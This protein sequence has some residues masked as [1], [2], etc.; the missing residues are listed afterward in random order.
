MMQVFGSPPSRVFHFG[1]GERGHISRVHE[2]LILVVHRAGNRAPAVSSSDAPPGSA[3]KIPGTIH[4]GTRDPPRRCRWLSTLHARRNGAVSP[5]PPIAPGRLG[6]LRA[7]SLR[8]VWSLAGFG[9]L[10][11]PLPAPPPIAFL[12]GAA[13]TYLDPVETWEG[14]EGVRLRLSRD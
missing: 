11:A 1:K 4:G 5:S 9:V 10:S 8:R 3:T 14:F 13:G 12:G 7:V 6:F 2:S